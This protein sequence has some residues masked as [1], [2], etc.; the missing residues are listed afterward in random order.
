M[1]DK[2]PNIPPMF[3]P[4]HVQS[5]PCSIPP[6]FIPHE[7]NI[8]VNL[9][10]DTLT[11]TVGLCP[12]S[13]TNLRVA[14]TL[15]TQTPPCRFMPDDYYFEKGHTASRTDM[16]AGKVTVHVQE[17]KCMIHPAYTLGASELC[18]CLRTSEQR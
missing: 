7:E 3:N 18:I 9:A 10:F 4:S 17:A 14:L 2:W 6:V 13:A 5:L 8:G 1:H 12:A 11:L 16:Y 15:D